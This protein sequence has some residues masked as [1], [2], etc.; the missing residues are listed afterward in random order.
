MPKKPKPKPERLRPLPQLVAE[1]VKRTDK[2]TAQR[3]LARILALPFS[4]KRPLNECK[5]D[6]Q[7]V[8]IGMIP[9]Q[10]MIAAAM[11]AYHAGDG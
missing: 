8:Y 11:E 4:K 6:G 1:L 7:F 2:I 5:M 9:F 3:L 10:Q